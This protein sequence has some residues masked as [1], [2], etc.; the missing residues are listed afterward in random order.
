MKQGKKNR[1]KHILRLFISTVIILYFPVVMS[2]V[3]SEYHKTVCIG[4]DADVKNNN[5]SILITDKNLERIVMRNYPLIKGTLLD[6]LH[7]TEMEARIEQIA[8]VKQCEMYTT[9]G[10]ILHVDVW[11]REPIMRVFG[12]D[13]RSYY[14]DDDLQRIPANFEMRTHVVIVNGAVSQLADTNGLVE[15]CKY[16]RDNDFWKATVEQIYIN[17]NLD[18]ILVPRVGN[19]IIEFGTSDKLEKKFELLHKLY[20]EEFDKHEW[21][22]YKKI[23]VKFKG[24]I[25]CTKR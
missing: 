11:Q 19:H 16:I 23:S 14:M 8:A 7:L 22:L 15:M 4:I 10:G 9:P 12:N 5:K 6:S 21:N 13:G 17:N 1:K 20:T 3:N 2:F 24:Q 18:F 25:I